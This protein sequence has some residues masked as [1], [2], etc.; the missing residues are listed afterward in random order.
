MEVVVYLSFFLVIIVSTGAGFVFYRNVHRPKPVISKYE[1]YRELY[2]KT[3]S[4]EALK[5]MLEEMEEK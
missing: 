5:Q 2:E 3:G 1:E 4:D